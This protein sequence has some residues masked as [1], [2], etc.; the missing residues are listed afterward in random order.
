[1][2]C[3]RLIRVWHSAVPNRLAAMSHQAHRI[4]LL[5]TCS[6]RNQFD[7]NAGVPISISDRAIMG[8]RTKDGVHHVS[9]REEVVAKTRQ[10]DRGVP[11]E[12][13]GRSGPIAHP[14]HR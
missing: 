7:R 1:M 9:L 12:A 6:A 14:V 5:S 10:P 8:A 11:L 4:W 13:R 2:T 3:G